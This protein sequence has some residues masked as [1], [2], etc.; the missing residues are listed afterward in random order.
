MAKIRKKDLIDTIVRLQQQVK[1]VKADCARARRAKAFAED[2]MAERYETLRAAKTQFEEGTRRAFQIGVEALGGQWDPD[3]SPDSQFLEVLDAHE[4]HLE[5]VEREMR[6]LAAHYDFCQKQNL[7]GKLANAI[8]KDWEVKTRL[9]EL[10]TCLG[11]EQIA[12]ADRKTLDYVRELKEVT[13][14]ASP[15]EE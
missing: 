14:L 11:R 5:A 15:G 13:G 2:Q 7:R 9:A 12:Q 6:T 4:E 10:L 8:R 3:E 1:E